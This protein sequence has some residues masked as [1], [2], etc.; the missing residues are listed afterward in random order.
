MADTCYYCGHD[1]Q[2]AH[3]VTFYDS[4]TER[5]ELLC[6]ECYAEWLESTKG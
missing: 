3:C 2:N 6:D 5:N 4:N 1:M